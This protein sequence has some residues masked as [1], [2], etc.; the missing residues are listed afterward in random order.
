MTASPAMRR[1]RRHRHP[2]RRRGPRRPCATWPQAEEEA[3]GS[4]RKSGPRHLTAGA[5]GA[6]ITST[7]ATSPSFSVRAASG[8]TLT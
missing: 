6:M 5:G 7:V 2:A 4:K 8:D 3:R 1:R